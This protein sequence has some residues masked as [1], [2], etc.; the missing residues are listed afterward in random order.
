LF[1]DGSGNLLNYLLSVWII[2]SDDFQNIFIR[3]KF[4]VLEGYAYRDYIASHRACADVP[5]VDVLKGMDLTCA[6]GGGYEQGDG[7]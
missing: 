5:F 2:I 6:V 1:G 7:K 3:L 4:T